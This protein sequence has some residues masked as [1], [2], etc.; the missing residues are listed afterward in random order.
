[1]ELRQTAHKV[2]IKDIINGKYIKGDDT[3]SNSLILNN[4]PVN[5]VNV[6]GSIVD[7][8]SIYPNFS[9]LTLDDGSGRLMIRNFDNK[10]I[11]NGLSIGGVILVIGKPREYNNERYIV[12]EIV[13]KIKD[14]KWLKVRELELKKEIEKTSPRSQ[15]EEV[16]KEDEKEFEDE[17]IQKIIKTLTELDSGNGVDFD[18]V[19]DKVN[20]PDA[21]KKISYLIERGDVFET[22]PGKLKVLE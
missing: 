18:T 4:K 5:R 21:E 8:P 1:M 3:S 11:L 19:I 13:K 14:L 17:T 2:R 20:A 6:V 12:A 15:E 10:N 7:H 22:S 16:I 9:Q